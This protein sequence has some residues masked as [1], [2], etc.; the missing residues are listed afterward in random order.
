MV[1]ISVKITGIHV[2]AVLNP[3]GVPVTGGPPIKYLDG[4]L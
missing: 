4:S 2:Y 3:T 1:N